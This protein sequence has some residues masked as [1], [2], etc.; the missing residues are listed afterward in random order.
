VRILLL[1]HGPSSHTRRWA[2]ALRQR[3]HDLLLLTA[4]ASPSPEAPER[5]VGRRSPWAALGYLSAVGAVRREMRAFRPDVTVAHFLPNYGL[6]AA[7]SGARPWML[8]CWGSDLL[9]N[10]RRSPL[11]RARARFVLRRASLVHVDAEVL[12]DAAVSL[13]ADPARVWTRAWGVD[14][15]ALA[16]AGG[17]G[18]SGGGAP[19]ILWTRQLLPVYDPGPFIRALGILKRRGFGFRASMAGDGPMRDHVSAWIREAGVEREVTLEGYVGEEPLRALYRASDLYVSVSRSDST[20]QSLL[21]AMASGLFPIVSDIAGN[22]EWV[23]HR[24][25][26][27]LVPVGDVDAIACAI[28]EA[29]RDPERGAMRA[30]ARA[31]VLERGSFADTID[32]LE[33]RLRALGAP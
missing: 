15:A 16:P 20:S 2:R 32:Q 29:W 27:Y 7:L 4:H 26:G 25:E 3:G 12:A 17:D 6:L 14:A 8:A 18:G 21:E 24:R 13:G 11:H 9:I 19:R 22:R 33:A 5:I 23:T 1:A 31:K 30:R 10:A 28:E